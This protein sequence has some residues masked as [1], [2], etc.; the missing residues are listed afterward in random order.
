M[1]PIKICVHVHVVVSVLSYMYPILDLKKTHNYAMYCTP[2]IYSIIT[3]FV[4]RMHLGDHVT[5][6]N[7]NYNITIMK[8]SFIGSYAIQCK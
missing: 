2:I 5:L 7:N 1:I 8:C 6:N 4:Y 3:L